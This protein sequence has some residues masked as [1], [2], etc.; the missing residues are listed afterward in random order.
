M[1]KDIIR[2]TDGKFAR[3]ASAALLKW[4][5]TSVPSGIVHIHG[6]QD[7]MIPPDRVHAGYW[8]EDGGHMMVY[9]RAKEI[10][11]IIEKEIADL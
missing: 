2:D 10:S 6:R 3:W 5:N 11:H 1:L 9:N 8:I 4:K 7:K